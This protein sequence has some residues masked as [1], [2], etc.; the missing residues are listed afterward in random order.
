M[1]YVI[2][3]CG[4]GGKT[5]YCKETAKKYSSENKTVCVITSTHM[6][7]NEKLDDINELSSI[8]VGK[9]YFFGTVDGEKVGAVSEDDY[10]K[11]CEKFDYVIVEADGSKMMPLKIPREL[12]ETNDDT[13]KDYDKELDKYKVNKK[14][15]EPAIYNNVDE[16]VIVMGL[17]SLGREFEV[18]TFNGKNASLS[19]K[20]FDNNLDKRSIEKDIKDSRLI[21]TEELIDEIIEKYYIEPLKKEFPNVIYKVHKTDFRKKQNYKNIKKLALV[22]CA[23]GFSK[24]FGEQNKLLAEICKDDKEGIGTKK[25]Y[26]LMADK[27]LETK[28]LLL[29]KFH[30]E[31]SYDDLTINVAI[32]SQYDEILKDK[33][34]DTKV[35]MIKN[36]N[37]KV[38]LSSSIRCAVENYR[39]FDALMF[40]NGDL[41][42]LPSY[43]LML[44]LYNSICSDNDLSSMYTDKPKNPAY[45]EKKYFDEILRID[46]DVGPKELLKKYK[47]CSYKYYIDEKY[48]FDIDTVDD[49][50]K[51]RHIKY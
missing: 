20:S 37:A 51:L 24:R 6:W 8:K 16:I 39:D 34:Y 32:V 22:L 3:V 28:K 12:D 42:I 26:Q 17:E 44:F 19:K 38:G 7:H 47:K 45:F 27:L 23:S 5:T 11:I 31:L 48:L 36:I 49:L 9:I 30:K 35:D 1:G 33:L 21:V 13:N 14:F 46:G 2:C 50:E 41:P 4:A 15:R 29:D 25:L 40:I 10:K 18:V 43:E